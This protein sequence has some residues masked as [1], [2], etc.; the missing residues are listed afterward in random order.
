MTRFGHQ[1]TQCA[2]VCYS[3]LQCV[4]VCYS[5]LQCVPA[6]CSVLQ[7][8]AV[9]C[10]VLQCVAVCCIVLQSS[11]LW[12]RRYFVYQIYPVYFTRKGTCNDDAEAAHS[13]SCVCTRAHV[14]SEETH[15]IAVCVRAFTPDS[16]A[17]LPVVKCTESSGGLMVW[18]YVY[19]HGYTF[20][21]I[22]IYS[23]HARV[24]ICIYIYMCVYIYIYIYIN[25]YLYECIYIY[26]YIHI[27]IWIWIYEYKHENINIYIY[28]YIYVYI[29]NRLSTCC[30]FYYGVV[31]ISSWKLRPLSQSAVSFIGSF[32][33]ETYNFKEPTNLSH[34]I[35]YFQIQ[36]R[37]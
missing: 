34:P 19:I 11:T 26:I 15:T 10:S 33:K 28:M 16:G 18:T 25:L 14:P 9:C 29:C 22:Y 24:F 35:P 2:A 23:V 27:D 8:A 12:S 36:I 31:L 20:R 4:A 13:G 21:Y 3:V 30:C 7:C 6:W 37:V 5:V 1:I 17:S 32:P